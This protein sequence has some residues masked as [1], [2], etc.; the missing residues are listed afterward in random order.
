MDIKPF[1]KKLY[2]LVGNS[3]GVKVTVTVIREK[4]PEAKP[5]K[6]QKLRKAV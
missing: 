5:T 3:Q 2:E 1:L 4:E 6:T